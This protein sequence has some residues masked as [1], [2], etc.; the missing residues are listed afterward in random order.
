MSDTPTIAQA[1]A[2][3]AADVGAVGKTKKSAVG[4]SYRGIDGVMDAVH[5]HFATHG[6]T[7]TLEDESIQF[8][9][10]E[11]GKS[12]QR[13]WLLKTRF[14]FTGPAGDSVSSA[15]FCE[16]LSSDD[17]GI[18]AAHSYGLKDVVTRLLTL[19]TNDPDADNEARNVPDMTSRAPAPA[20]VPVVPRRRALSRLEEALG[21]KADEA[22]AWFA[23][24]FGDSRSPVPETE[25]EALIAVALEG[26]PVPMAG[27]G[28]E[29]ALTESS[30]SASPP[31]AAGDVPSSPA[32]EGPAAVRAAL[33]EA[34]S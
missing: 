15:V 32:V 13:H 25:L 14:T 5:P 9:L 18:G 4:Y 20:N 6:V 16:A 34:K 2:A 19:P 11:R 22:P 28:E 17:K 7:I 29:L 23:S 30:G 10:V 1:L 8:E 12:W 31:E 33:K 21:E 3:I 24:K 27:E 26:S